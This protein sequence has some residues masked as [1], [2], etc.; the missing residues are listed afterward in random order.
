MTSPNLKQ[1]L[2]QIVNSI[3]KG[4]YTKASLYD[5]QTEVEQ[6]PDGDDKT[7]F[8]SILTLSQK[9]NE[10]K[11]YIEELSKGN[12]QTTPPTNNQWVSAYKQ[13]HANLNHLVWQ[14]QRIAEG[15]LN[16]NI[17]YLGDLSLY[18]NKLI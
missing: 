3:A 1:R 15:D 16:Q 12:I 2:T 13:L 9:N 11:N 10:S 6:L 14:I 18:F 4:E 5:I 17:D 8:N 7:L